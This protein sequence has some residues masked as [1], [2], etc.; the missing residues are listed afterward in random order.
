MSFV[1]S[2]VE[3]SNKYKHE[4]KKNLI[5]YVWQLETWELKLGCRLS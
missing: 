5:I 2:P 4:R 1:S 3:N